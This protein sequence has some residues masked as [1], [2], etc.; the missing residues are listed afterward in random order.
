MNYVLPDFP[1]DVQYEVE[2]AKIWYGEKFKR[3]MQEPRYQH[4]WR[5]NPED[6]LIVYILSVWRVFL[7][8]TDT[9]RQWRAADLNSKALEFLRQLTKELYFEKGF[10]YEGRRL[11]TML[12]IDGVILDRVMQ[13]FLRCGTWKYFEE[14][15][16]RAT[17]PANQPAAA[18]ASAT[19]LADQATVAEK[20]NATT[21]PAIE[22]APIEPLEEPPAF[23]R[24][25]ATSPVLSRPIRPYRS[26]Q[27]RAVETAL[28]RNPKAKDQEVCQ[29]ID[30]ELG[31]KPL[32]AWK[33]NA[34]ERGWVGAYHG[35]DKDKVEKYISVVRCDLRDQGR[36]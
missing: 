29:L 34:G 36:I 5:V 32:A 30:E 22:K 19:G 16:L 26:E 14:V 11:P 1:P 31:V 25:I 33:T 12:A 28:I 27:K 18:L 3:R 13:K 15:R 20:I 35:P 24:D 17:K 8:E 21:P 4:Y 23:T 9:R 2:V 10:D 6:L 7:R